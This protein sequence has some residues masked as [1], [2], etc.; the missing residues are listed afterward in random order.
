MRPIN[1]AIIV[2]SI[3]ALT[4]GLCYLGIKS[5]MSPSRQRERCLH[6]VNLALGIEN[7]R[8][9]NGI[10]IIQGWSDVSVHEVKNLDGSLLSCSDHREKMRVALKSRCPE[11]K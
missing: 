11:V 5:G 2:A 6:Q 4:S 10:I 7:S 9:M 3:L 1:N 8:C